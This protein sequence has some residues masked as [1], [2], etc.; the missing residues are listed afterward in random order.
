MRTCSL[1][2]YRS[3]VG[4]VEQLEVVLL[5]SQVNEVP[6]KQKIVRRWYRLWGWEFGNISWCGLPFIATTL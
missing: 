6:E 4:K 1:L 2:T 3:L 5:H